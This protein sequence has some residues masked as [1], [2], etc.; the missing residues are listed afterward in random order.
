MRHGVAELT[1]VRHGESTANAAF[2]RAEAAG[3]TETGLTGRDKDIPLTTVGEAQAAALG[4]GLSAQPPVAPR[5]DVVICSPY[6]R[7]RETWRIAA[8]VAAEGGPMLPESWLDPRLGD[9]G[10]G[11]LELL[12]S[13]AIALRFPAEAARRRAAGELSYRPPGGESFADVADRVAAVLADLDRRHPERRVLMVAHDAVVLAVRQV[14]EGLTTDDLAAIL[15]DGPV[16]NAS[17]TRFV[18]DGGRLV[19]TEYNVT[20]HLAG[21]G[22]AG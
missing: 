4:A 19:L 20:A 2:A 5:P 8:R 22:R 10:M 3:A 6:L 14:I 21:V 18:R 9:R 12:T 11:R 16:A 1:V 15:A 13:A 7:A 17:I